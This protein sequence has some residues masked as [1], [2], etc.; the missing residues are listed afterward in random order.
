MCRDDNPPQNVEL[1]KTERVCQGE[2]N[3]E[4]V[5]SVLDAMGYS[6]VRCFFFMVEL[7]REAVS[8]WR[9]HVLETDVFIVHANC[10]DT[11]VFL[12]TVRF[13]L[14]LQFVWVS[15][16]LQNDSHQVRPRTFSCA[17]CLG[18]P[19]QSLRH[20]CCWMFAASMF[21]ADVFLSVE[22]LTAAFI[23]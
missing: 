15:N 21:A 1:A 6:F 10:K 20:A 19:H 23:C 5:C 8:T 4:S 7:L 16:T 18:P 11:D 12:S 13:F 14:I 9:R 17:R 22:I 2:A 3:N